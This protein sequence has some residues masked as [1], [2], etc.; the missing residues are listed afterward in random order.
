MLPK[1][2]RY[3]L[4]MLQEASFY[5]LE[6]LQQIIRKKAPTFLRFGSRVLKTQ[7]LTTDRGIGTHYCLDPGVT[8]SI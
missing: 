1:E 8:I 6:G 3:L 4:E 2:R 7:I 5:R